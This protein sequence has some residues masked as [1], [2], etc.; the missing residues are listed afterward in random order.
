MVARKLAFLLHNLDNK[1][2]YYKTLHKPL[3][4]FLAAQLLLNRISAPSSLDLQIGYVSTVRNRL[5]EN[6]CEM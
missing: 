1:F 4:G 3:L 5:R 2:L 6:R